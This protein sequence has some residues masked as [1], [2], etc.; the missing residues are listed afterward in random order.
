M[1]SGLSLPWLLALIGGGMVASL[2]G[3]V[4]VN[5]V[6]AVTLAGAAWFGANLVVWVALCLLLA[7]TEQP[8][9]TWVMARS[10]KQVSF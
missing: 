7:G 8:K 9:I 10:S 3:M 5:W 1:P 6:G 4:V 2:L